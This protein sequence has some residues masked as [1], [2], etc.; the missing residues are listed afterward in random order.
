MTH[1][2]LPA[3]LVASALQVTVEVSRLKTSGALHICFC[4]SVT[5]VDSHFRPMI[6]EHTCIYNYTTCVC[7]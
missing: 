5:I 3:V 2:T 4:P 1:I 7:Q 6:C